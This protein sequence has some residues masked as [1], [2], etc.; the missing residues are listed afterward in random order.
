MTISTET[1]SI[2]EI[3]E[4]HGQLEAF[5]KKS[6]AAAMRIGELLTEQ[7][8]KLGHGNWGAWAEAS[9]PFGDRTARRYM[10]IYAERD[11]LKSDNV[12]DLSEAY[13]LL[14]G[15]PRVQ[16]SKEESREALDAAD[17]SIAGA[18]KCMDAL[19]C[20]RDESL[21]REKF[22]TFEEYL[23]SHGWTAGEFERRRQWCADFRAAQQGQGSMV[24]V[25]ER[26][27]AG[28]LM[29]DAASPTG[30]AAEQEG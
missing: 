5:A 23:R 8:S 6:L 26:A 30:F 4:L 3:T 28:E 14:A 2:E 21:Y 16:M 25:I 15:E 10:A 27:I 1:T 17:R 29:P 19:L 9:L 7:K 13:R 24:D 22:A 20:I 11:R 12:S 18:L